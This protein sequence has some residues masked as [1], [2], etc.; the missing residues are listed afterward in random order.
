MGLCDAVL[1]ASDMDGT[2]LTSDHRVSA[3]NRAAIERFMADGGH[4]A[5]ATGR[6][7]QGFATIEPRV[8][9]NA[10][11]IL[12]NG[13]C[14]YDYGKQSA[15]VTRPLQH[16]YRR[17]CRAVLDAFDGLPLE[18]HNLDAIYVYQPT[19]YSQ[20][21]FDAIG[22]TPVVCDDYDALPEPWLKALFTDDEN[23]LQ[24]VQAFIQQRYGDWFDCV[25]S[26]KYLLE[27]QDKSANKGALV[28][29]LA[30]RVGARRVYCVGDGENDLSMAERFDFFA[31]ANAVPAVKA[32]A[33][34]VVGHCNDNAL[35]QVIAGIKRDLETEGKR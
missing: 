9:Y 16:D 2:L 14:V 25:F 21:H 10:P 27:L 22:V 31:P 28:A 29:W 13:S 5:V 12:S 26:H 33:R 4:F 20:G 18:V 3:A 35:A 8:P 30:E 11:C 15:L 32:K 34:Q 6:S 17:V 7:L 24:Q 23:R 19:L 1:L